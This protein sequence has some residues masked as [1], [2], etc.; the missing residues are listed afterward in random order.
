MNDELIV[1]NA[2]PKEI[3]KAFTSLP[4]PDT[5]FKPLLSE[6]QQEMVKSFSVQSGMK[7]DW[8]QK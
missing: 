7:L 2:S 4:A 6:E 1:R 8:S 5:S 3:Q